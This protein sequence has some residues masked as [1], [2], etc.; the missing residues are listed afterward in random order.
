M[1]FCFFWAQV[2]FLILK[3]TTIVGL[4]SVEAEYVAAIRSVIQAVKEEN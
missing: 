3:E 4:S 1:D 2:H